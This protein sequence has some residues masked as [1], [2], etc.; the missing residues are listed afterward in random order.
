MNRENRALKT[1]IETFKKYTTLATSSASDTMSNSASLLAV[2]KDNI[3]DHAAVNLPTTLPPLE[4]SSVRVQT[5]ILAVT[6]NNLSYARNGALLHWWDTYPIPSNAPPPYN[7][8]QKWGIVPAWGFGVIIES[9][10]NALKPGT[11]LWGFWPMS[12][13]PVDLK[14]E[15]S[16][17]QGHWKEASSHRKNLMP[18]YARYSEVDTALSTNEER[19]A[20]TASLLPLHSAGTLFNRYV[21][22]EARNAPTLQPQH[23]LGTGLP[24]SAQDADLSSAVL[25]S[26]SAASRSGR[27]LASQI[28]GNRNRAQFGPLAF[29]QVTRT[30]HLLRSSGDDLSNRVVTYADLTSPE[31]MSWIATF[32]PKRIVMV[33]FGVPFEVIEEFSSA[34]KS[35]KLFQSPPS[36]TLIGIGSEMRILSKDETRAKMASGESLGRVQFNASGLREQGIEAEGPEAFFKNLDDDFSQWLEAGATAGLEL[37]W[38]TGIEGETGLAAVW[39]DLC[40]SRVSPTKSCVIKF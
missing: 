28:D 32:K 25:V 11:M 34:T 38:A 23:P 4:Q 24:W 6:S 27:S 17:P 29:L 5:K 22:P 10:I 7:D 12:S 33:D 21:F 8:Q 30:P 14:L 37:H 1:R 18:L 26:L 40:N 15:S 16:K 13:L 19:Q 31:T 35:S 3:A 39:S 36:I 2:S 20:W 9:T